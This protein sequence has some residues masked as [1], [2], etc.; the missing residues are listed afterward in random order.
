[1]KKIEEKWK[2]RL[3]SNFSSFFLRLYLIDS[4]NFTT[5][6]SI[7]SVSQVLIAFITG[8]LGPILLQ[9]VKNSL[10]NKKE[11]KKDPLVEDFEYDAIVDEQIEN[12]K[13][14][15]DFDRVW[16]E[17]FHNGGHFSA[18]G[19]SMNKFSMFYEVVAVG[20]SKTMSQF[21]NVPTSLFAKSLN[22]I[23]KNGEVAVEDF[24]DESK[25]HYGLKDMAESTGCQSIYIIPLKRLS[26]NKM[27]GIM[28][29]EQVK[30]K[31]IFTP[32]EKSRIKE[33]GTFLAGVLA[34][35]QLPK[36]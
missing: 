29:T 20:I 35:Q 1:M 6:M 36:R 5:R 7:D 17:Q 31:R 22:E 32:A 4:R 19:R 16:I 26:D 14:E 9:Y 33:I 25:A 8:V 27:L 18:S 15:L 30:E 12:L 28:G 11:V 23:S 2:E 34:Q 21:Q 3:P 10:A 13:N 24:E